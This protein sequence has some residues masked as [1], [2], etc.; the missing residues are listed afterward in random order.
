MFK[1]G[2]LFEFVLLILLVGMDPWTRFFWRG[3][4]REH[5]WHTQTQEKTTATMVN[6][7][8]LIHHGRPPSRVAAA[9][10]GA[11]NLIRGLS[12]TFCGSAVVGG[13][14]GVECGRFVVA[15]TA[16]YT[17]KGR[18]LEVPHQSTGGVFWRLHCDS[19]A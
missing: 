10:R 17:V 8:C 1:N 5:F 3:A 6:V 2:D 19:Y 4:R 18:I 13:G 9:A 16:I 11:A 15:D 7:R 14:A 12:G